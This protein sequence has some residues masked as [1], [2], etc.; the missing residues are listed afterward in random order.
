MIKFEDRD[1]GSRRALLHYLD[2]GEPEEAH[3]VDLVWAAMGILTFCAF[4]TPLP[5]ALISCRDDQRAPRS[6]RTVQKSFQ[7]VKSVSE[8]S[9]RRAGAARTHPCGG[10]NG[11]YLGEIRNSP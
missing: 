3:G 9:V 11:R 4:V 1:V 5:G 10:A 8:D 7:I 6:Q 2:T